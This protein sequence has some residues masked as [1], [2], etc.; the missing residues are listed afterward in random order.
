MLENDSAS[1][2]SGASRV[3]D[4]GPFQGSNDSFTSNENDGTSP[5]NGEERSPLHRQHRSANA[6]N[7]S[8]RIRTAAN[9]ISA[10]ECDKFREVLETRCSGAGSSVENSPHKTGGT[11]TN[12]IY[13]NSSACSPNRTRGNLPGPK[14]NDSQ[15]SLE[16][17]IARLNKEMEDIKVECQE[18]VDSHGRERHKTQSELVKLE[19]PYRSPRL[20]PRMGTRL[21]SMKQT[22]EPVNNTAWTNG[23][24]N[25]DTNC[26]LRD[27]RVY[28]PLI[29]GKNGVTN[30]TING[31]SNGTAN[32]ANTHD[33]LSYHPGAPLTLEL[34]ADTDPSGGGI[35]NGSVL[36]L[37]QPGDST[38]SQQYASD[39][40]N[41]NHVH[42]SANCETLSN[43]DSTNLCKS[44]S[45]TSVEKMSQTLNGE[46]RHRP[47]HH[48]PRYQVP[49]DVTQGGD[50]MQELYAQYAD[51][52]Y[53]NQANLQHTM[54][55]QQ[56]LFSQ[57]LGQQPST[58]PRNG[59]APTDKLPP[60]PPS[61]SI[62]TC[63]VGG[64]GST[65]PMSMDGCGSAGG[66]GMEWVVK[67]RADGSR[68][69]TRRP[70]RNKML[71]ERARKIEHERHGLTTDDDAQSEMKVGR[72]WSKEDRKA[73]LS[74]ARDHRRKKET[75][76]RQRMETLKENEEKGK[77]NGQN[78]ILALSHRKM[79]KH[80]GKKVF[81]DFTTVQE[82]MAH[83]T[84]DPQAKTYNPLLSVTTV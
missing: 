27:R 7:G 64:D 34:A 82:M 28:Q 60:T 26:K 77:E 41:H 38:L 68:Y 3:C 33:S 17:E 14:R 78:N 56:K 39:I 30:G 32:G 29:N 58:P 11:T 21:D 20:V 5:Q 25:K 76:M 23:G 44:Q 66:S 57:Q 70:V 36:S 52:M 69:V 35:I 1:P 2:G 37:A 47:H 10:E 65:P 45:S 42:A 61:G 12:H 72:Y 79:M 67:R 24:N 83:G 18:I 15:S 84:R 40:V 53:T 43:G 48:H 16:R 51:V 75:M 50:S 81:D 13:M 46:V 49:N 8:R 62:G 71:K 63:P 54:M 22:T 59:R 6:P 55:V 4:G 9:E 19:P 80:K 31:T 73:H 74:K